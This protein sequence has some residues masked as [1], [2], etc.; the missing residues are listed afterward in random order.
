VRLPDD[1]AL[2]AYGRH[3]AGSVGLLSISVFGVP[4]ARDFALA[5]GHT[6]QLVNI[7]RDVD[8]DAAL[9]RVYVPVSYLTRFGIEDAPARTIVSDAR[10]PSV[11]QALAAEV[12]AGFGT[13]AGHLTQ[14]DRAA[15]K[16][17]ILMMEGY[18]RIFERLQSRGWSGR[19]S[20]LRLTTADRLQL[21]GLAMRPA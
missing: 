8:E 21:L 4:A 20:R 19:R 7:L 9:D 6:L 11:C 10:F 1:A 13:A 17:A 2:R 3:V 12:E 5:L 16:P 14:L 18:R 15:L